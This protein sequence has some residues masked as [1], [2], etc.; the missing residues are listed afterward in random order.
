[1]LH[2]AI[3]GLDRSWRILRRLFGIMP[4]ALPADYPMEDM[5]SWMRDELC[6]DMGMTRAQLQQELDGIR[7][8][9]RGVAPRPVAA[10]EAKPEEPQ[11]KEELPLEADKELMVKYGLVISFE[12]GERNFF[13]QRVRDFEKVLSEKT[14]AGL[15]RNILMT[16][17]QVLR[18]DRLLADNTKNRTGS[19]E[20]R[21]NM[22][23]RKT[24]DDTYRDQ[25]EQLRKNASWFSAVGG[26]YAFAGVL[27][28]ITA[29]MQMYY[30][31]GD[32]AL[33]DGIFTA[34]EIQVELRRSVQAPEPRYRAGLVVFLNMAKSF[35]FDRNWKN[36]FPPSQFKKIDVAWKATSM[37]EDQK[38]GEPLPD[39]ENEGE[40]PALKPVTT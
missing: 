34:T 15:A 11:F 38:E 7:G 1:V 4:V 30:G 14:T 29:A 12:P 32:T 28:D 5:R 37:A 24:L 17:L 16:E 21:A 36:P 13:M 8:L 31:M 22:N 39:L 10:E 35:L 9:W 25:L 26:K 40:Y 18:I 20:W 6:A 2:Q 33:V 23:L 19:S 27:S 3:C